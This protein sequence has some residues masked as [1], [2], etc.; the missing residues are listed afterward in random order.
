[1]GACHREGWAGRGL[2]YFHLG[3]KRRIGEIGNNAVKPECQGMGIGTFQYRKVLEIFRKE[4]MRFAAVTTGLDEA[5]APARAAYEKVGFRKA[6][7]MVTYY[8][9]V[10]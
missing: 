7:A 4:D 1:M 6:I 9:K 8:M 5:H 3:Q 2:H 10:L